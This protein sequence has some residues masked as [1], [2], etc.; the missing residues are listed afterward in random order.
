MARLRILTYPEPLLR[1]KSAPVAE[2]DGDLHRLLDDMLETLYLAP[3]V[4]LA[5][6]QVGVLRRLMIIDVSVGDE[7][8]K[9]MELVNPKIVEREGV[10]EA[11]EGCL[12]IPEYSAMVRRAAK[13]RVRAQDRHGAWFERQVHDLEARA[14]QHELDHLDGILFLDYLSPLKRDLAKRKL[15]KLKRDEETKPR[16]RRSTGAPAL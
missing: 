9:L 8:G 11:E 4:G 13:V 1:Q 15:R 2:F 12:S 10:E 16:A 14:V 5:A 7:P 6:P 3:G